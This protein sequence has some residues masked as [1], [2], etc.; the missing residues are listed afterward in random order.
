MNLV[1]I[2]GYKIKRII[3]YIVKRPFSRKF[4]I[5]LDPNKEFTVIY[6]IKPDTWE[7]SYYPACFGHTQEQ[8][9]KIF[10]SAEY[11]YQTTNAVVSCNSDVVQ[12]KKGVYWYKYNEE[13]FL[14]WFK[15]I[16]DQNVVGYKKGSIIVRQYFSTKCI[17]GKV[18][19]LLGVWDYHWGHFMYQ[20]LPKLF[21]ASEAGLLDDDISILIPCNVDHTILEIIKRHISNY[22]K[23]KLVFASLKVNYLC[24]D[25]YFAPT[26]QYAWGDYNFRLDYTS[27]M[28][29]RVQQVINKYVVLPLVN[30]IKE[31]KGSYDK[32]FLGRPS[33]RRTLKNFDEI[34]KYFKDRGFKD[35]DPAKL[36][37]TE[38]ADLFYHA[39]EVVAL[40]G[41][42]LLN[43]IFGN[44]TKCLCLNNYKMSTD[45]GMYLQIR[46]YVSSCINV[47]GKDDDPSYHTNYF[48]PLSKVELAYNALLADKYKKNS[49]C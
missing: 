7:D 20:Y 35:I 1:K 5:L 6:E 14:T 37:L 8:H 17:K 13:E 42:S 33:T 25:L 10:K 15:G 11:I 24:E 22:P 18:L 38:K 19:S 32:I 31:N 47:T 16:I 29:Q 40:Y 43:L 44:Q 4:N 21:Y 45:V 30:E 39:K 2:V 27:C 28:S 9:L 49:S 34:H 48:I 12:T 41:S 26:V 36:S 46:N 3:E 23:S